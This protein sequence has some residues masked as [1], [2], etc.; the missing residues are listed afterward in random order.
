MQ[1]YDFSQLATL[2]NI[3]SYTNNKEGVNQIGKIFRGFMEDLGFKTTVYKREHIGNHLHFTSPCKEGKR[4]LL[5]GHLDTVFPPQSFEGFR[6]DD[7]W[8]YGPGVCDMKG[9][10]HIALEALRS[11]HVKYKEISNIEYEKWQFQ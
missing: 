4:L 10:N 1:K 9:G 5:L 2:I 6:E 8:I 7:E 3:N 11:L